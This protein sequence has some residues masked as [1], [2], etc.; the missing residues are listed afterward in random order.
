[1]KKLF[2]IISSLLI[3]LSV[4]A[5]SPEKMSYQSIIR[6]AADALIIDQTI[7]MQISILQGS[8]SGTEV[9]VETHTPNTN[10]NGLVS[11]EIGS[12]TIVFGVFSTIDWS[13]GP[14]FLKTETDPTGGTSYTISGTI[15]LMSVPYALHANT[16]ENI[17]ETDPLFS[18]SVS[19][20]IGTS[21]T[22]YWN[23]KLS[24]ETDPLFS[25]STAYGINQ[26]DT[27]YWNNKL[28]IEIDGSIT[29]ELQTLNYTNDTLTISGTNYVILERTTP[30]IWSG[31]CTAYGSDAGWNTYCTDASDFNTTD[32]YLSVNTNGTFT[33]IR[34]GYYRVN[35]WC[36]SYGNQYAYISLMVNGFTK[37]QGYGPCNGWIIDNSMD[38][39]WRFE[40]GDTFYIR[41]YNP[42]TYAYHSYNANG[43]GSR[44]QVSYEGPLD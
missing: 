33:V 31:G 19:A 11:L 1:M 5:Q 9:Y 37:Q 39:I 30:K 36:L 14:Y 6:D 15:Q 23:N 25:A 42:G 2:T 41:V 34:E 27:S 18:S 24:V 35:F 13:D 3:T 7:G 17:N 43:Q 22:A 16:V 4:Y 8:V 12:G 29:N 32:G 40:A 10:N 28:D 44:L 26:T 20:S 21:D 38:V